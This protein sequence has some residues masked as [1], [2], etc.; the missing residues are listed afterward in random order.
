MA[1]EYRTFQG[2]AQTATAIGGLVWG[3]DSVV[4]AV[5]PW[6]FQPSTA[7]VKIEY[8]HEADEDNP[9]YPGTRIDG[10]TES[11]ASGTAC[12]RSRH[13]NERYVVTYHIEIQGYR[14]T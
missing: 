14:T 1:I 12:T 5:A 6:I 7:V 3:V 2:S 9:Q 10:A 4:D 8:Y 13:S 11:R